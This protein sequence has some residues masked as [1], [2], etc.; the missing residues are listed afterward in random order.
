MTVYRLSEGAV[1]NASVSLD[2][3]SSL[4][5]QAG[6]FEREQELD[7]SDLDR[8]FFTS[9]GLS[10]L[11][12][13][14]AK[15][16]CGFRVLTHPRATNTCFEKA[17]LLGRW[18][19]LQVIK[20][21]YL[22]EADSGALYCAVV[23]ETGCFLDK[24][25][26]ARMVGQLDANFRKAS[27]LPENMTFGT[28]SPFVGPKE[29]AAHGGKIERIVFDTE[30]LIAKKHEGKLDDFSF[31]TNHRMS[32]Q[33]NYY[34]CYRMLKELYPKSV[35]DEEI[36]N[37]SFSEQFTRKKGAVRISYA[38]SSLS[39]RVAKFVEET[40]GYG[41]VTINNDYSDELDL[42]DIMTMPASEK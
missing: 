11:T 22:E 40:H 29:L 13:Y 3:D 41:D 7:K 30:T 20:A 37:L 38:F 24:E 27:T 19:P 10:F 28:C 16:S 15:R 36:L 4:V 18:S 31:G 32:V 5:A 17:E 35:I 39:Y 1:P 9:M 14:C 21:L 34:E 33:L 42:P 2:D 8:L 25:N 6:S 26:F 12:D 23:P